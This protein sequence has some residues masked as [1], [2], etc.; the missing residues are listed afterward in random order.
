MKLILLLQVL[1]SLVASTPTI[2]G[3]AAY[4]RSQHLDE[5]MKHMTKEQL[6]EYFRVRTQIEE[7]MKRE[8]EE[9]EKTRKECIE[10]MKVQFPYLHV[11]ISPFAC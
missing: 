1:L 2:L 5:M 9:K 7:Q 3:Q 10:R 6:V 11:A 8:E 4:M